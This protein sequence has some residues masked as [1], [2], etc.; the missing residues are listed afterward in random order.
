MAASGSLAR[1]ARGACLLLA[2]LVAGPASGL[3]PGDVLIPR[4]NSGGALIRLDPRS[5]VIDVFVDL[6]AE[7]DPVDLAVEAEGDFFV[8]DD[9]GFAGQ[10]IVR[11]FRDGSGFDPLTEDFTLE[12]VEGITLL[13]GRLYGVRDEFIGDPLETPLFFEIDTTSGAVLPILT[14]ADFE[15]THPPGSVDDLE[16]AKGDTAGP[17]CASGPAEDFVVWT[18]PSRRLLTRV[19][20][21]GACIARFPGSGQPQLSSSPVGLELRG[22]IAVVGLRSGE[23]ASLTMDDG[24]IVGTLGV[25]LG[26]VNDLEFDTLTQR[27]YSLDRIARLLKAIDPQTGAVEASWDLAGHNVANKFEVVPSFV[28]GEIPAAPAPARALLALAFFTALA[29]EAHRRR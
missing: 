28:W 3:Q 23:L 6:G 5:G 18:E 16:A 29:L 1:V 27:Y 17:T 19:P 14:K 10:R 4:N 11:V 20:I 8:L 7:V 15:G 13:E 9:G 25:D 2:A 24:E 22:G 12:D 26:W 21:S